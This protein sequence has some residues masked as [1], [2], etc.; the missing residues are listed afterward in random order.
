MKLIK[1]IY[2]WIVSGL[3]VLFFSLTVY[4]LVAG[5]IAM[6][7]KEMISLFGYT[8]SVVP[9]D[10][11]EPEI[12]VG[13]SVIAKKV[14]FEELEIGNDIIYHYVTDKIDIFIVHRIIREED[15][16]FITQGINN[17]SEDDVLVTEDNYVAKVVW[18][19]KAANIGELV[20]HNRDLIFLILTIVLL[21]ICVNGVFD[22]LKILE[23]KKK[24]EYEESKKEAISST[25]ITD[26]L[27]EKLRKEV[28]K[29]LMNQNNENDEKK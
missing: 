1:K 20:L 6:K 24:L 19:G 14:D 5:T 12:M 22:I 16:G 10:S 8:Y 3:I 17:N 9:T 25:E 13:D 21:L 11:M 29:E 4:V 2:Q 18:S 23:A 15:G 7:N 28:E 26:E 27:R